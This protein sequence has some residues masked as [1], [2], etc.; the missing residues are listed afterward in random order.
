MQITISPTP[1][2]SHVGGVLTRIWEGTDEHGQRVIATVA[3][4]VVPKVSVVPAS[5]MLVESEAAQVATLV[6]KRVRTA[7]SL[8]TACI[9]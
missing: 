5:P 3:T 4:V 6:G 2:L 8:N 1:Q 7:E 9:N